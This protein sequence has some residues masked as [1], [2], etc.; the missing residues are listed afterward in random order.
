[1]NE[2]EHQQQLRHAPVEADRAV[3]AEPLYRE[4]MA[5]AQRLWPGD[6]PEVAILA[7]GGDRDVLMLAVHT[8]GGALLVEWPSDDQSVLMTGPAET[9]FEG[10]IEL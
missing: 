1:M 7:R 8:R 4:A 3:D 6:H 10:E 5:V 2:D 9:V